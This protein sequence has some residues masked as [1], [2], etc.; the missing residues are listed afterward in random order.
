MNM[1]LLKDSMTGPALTSEQTLEQSFNKEIA[2]FWQTGHFDSFPGKDEVRINYAYFIHKQECPDLVIVQGR[3]EGYLKYKE[4]AFDL[5]HQGYNIFLIDHRGQGISQ[6]MLDNPKKGYVKRFDDYS[7]DLHR[8]ITEVVNKAG[9]AQNSS[10]KP[11]VLAHSMGSAITVRLLQLYPDC[12]QAAVLASPM[13]GINTGLIPHWLATVLVGTGLR[14]NNCL[15]GQPWY[16][17][18]QGDHQF[19][20]FAVNPLTHSKLR[21]Q[22][23]RDAYQQY[24]DM[25]LGGVTTHWLHQA[26]ET[27]K[28][29]FQQL[30]NLSVPILVLQS[31]K[32]IIVDNSEQNRFCRELNKLKPFSCPD[33]KAITLDGA[34]HELFFESDK[35]RTPAITHA[36]N[37]FNRHAS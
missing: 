24:P 33:G 13:I 29:M 8:F 30:A 32:D 21:Y 26:F 19:G 2:E 23:L 9:T 37:W 34:K 36:L 14:L 35:Y 18:G 15:G 11:F 16:F 31:G 20:A 5:F 27:N 28:K 4:L 6:R 25:K 17:L 12:I 3:S 7:E 10:V 1:P 22:L